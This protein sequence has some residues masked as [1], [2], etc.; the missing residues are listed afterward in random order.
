M[1][2]TRIRV[3]GGNSDVV[4]ENKQDKLNE[5]ETI[6]K[7][8]A[9]K[10][11]KLS[12]NSIKSYV[13]KLNRLSILCLNH[14]FYNDKFLMTPKNVINKIDNSA[15]KSK[16][17]YIGAICK[18][19]S[20][21]PVDPSILKQYHD[22]MNNYKNETNKTRDKNQATQIN[23]EKS[24]SMEDIK[25]KI[26]K[27]KINDE[28][29]LFDLVIVLFYF[30]NTDNFI[31]RNDLPNFKI[32]YE[33]YIRKPNMNKLY[34]YLTID[35]KNKPLKIVMN[36]YKTAPTYGKK[37]FNISNELKHVLTIYL[38]QLKKQPGDNLFV[39]RDGMTPYTKTAFAYAIERAMK[40]VLGTPINVDLARQIITTNWYKNNPLAS[41]EQKDEFA[42]RFL[43]SASTNFEY[44]RNNLNH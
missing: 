13:S 40:N 11:G 9:T 35:R 34:N 36:N 43:H 16:K 17:D 42:S 14:S 25:K 26:I 6:F 38:T 15:L 3:I 33:P 22:A 5:L 28:F 41:K 27:F 39:M 1:S 32:T 10:K 18:Y 4:F 23:V 19:L 12:D 44:M 30:G 31:P 37:E 2:S 8:M 20:Y 29:D 21:K 7:N 24:L